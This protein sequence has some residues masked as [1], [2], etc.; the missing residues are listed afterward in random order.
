[1]VCA[2]TSSNSIFSPPLVSGVSPGVI[3]AVLW[4]GYAVFD[5]PL[6]SLGVWLLPPGAGEGR[7]GENRRC[8]LAVQRSTPTTFS[9]HSNPKSI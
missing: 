4:Q 9:S 3:D 2:K 7:D 8:V 6:A 1:M 5:L